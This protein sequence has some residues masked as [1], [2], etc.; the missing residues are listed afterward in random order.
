MEG[1]DYFKPRPEDL[2][3]IKA[4]GFNVIRVPFEWARLVTGWQPGDPL[5]ST[6][7]PTYLGILDEVVQ[8]ATE[9]QIFVVLDMHDFLKYWSGWNDQVCVNGSS[10]Y[11]QLLA[12]TWELLA[13]HFRDNPAVLGYD[14]MNEPVRQEEGEPCGSCNWHAIA[15]SVVDAIRT[16]DTNHVR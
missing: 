15:Q 14:I 4:L 16:Q 11:Q 7:N 6:L 8:M 12:H 9:R 5:P 2:D 13:V 3:S 10:D 1:T